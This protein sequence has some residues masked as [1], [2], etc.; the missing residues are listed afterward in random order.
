M[1]KITLS[2]DADQLGWLQRGLEKVCD[3]EANTQLDNLV[4]LINTSKRVCEL[5]DEAAQAQARVHTLQYPSLMSKK[6][7]A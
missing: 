7:G 5:N 1:Y 6:A 3:E 2:F 4:I